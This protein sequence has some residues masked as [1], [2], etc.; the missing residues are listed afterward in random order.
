MRTPVWNMSFYLRVL[1]FIMID[2]MSLVV[3]GVSTVER[4]GDNVLT[5]SRLVN[6]VVLKL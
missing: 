3:N 5:E 4:S 6:E 1:S 2:L